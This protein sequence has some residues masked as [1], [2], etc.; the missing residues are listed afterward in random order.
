MPHSMSCCLFEETKD[1]YHLKD[2]QKT[3][4]NDL[5]LEHLIVFNPSS[6]ESFI[7]QFTKKHNLKKPYTFFCLKGPSLFESTVTTK[8]ST[9][10]FEEFNL[11]DKKN[12]ITHSMYLYPSQDGQCRFYIA[13]IKRELI[14]QFQL[15]A[16]RSNL[17]LVRISPATLGMLQLY[18]K[19]K[20]T[21]FRHSQLGMD[22]EQNN[23]QFDQLVDQAHLDMLKNSSTH[24]IE[25]ESG[26]ILPALGLFMMRNQRNE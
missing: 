6:I 8:T 17:N 16:L 9:P 26:H 14:F 22:L 12:I 13:G 24:A 19:L 5:Q 23:L 25:N 21:D 1:N 20:G 15:L 11:P 2:Y 3:E 18:K 10:E 7:D 4:L